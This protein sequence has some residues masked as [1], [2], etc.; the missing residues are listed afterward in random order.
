MTLVRSLKC[1]QDEDKDV[2]KVK[3][4]LGQKRLPDKNRVASESVVIKSLCSQWDR[5]V[6]EHG[7]LY[8][9]WTDHVTSRDTLQAV[10][11]IS[12]R[13]KVL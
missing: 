10:V 7:L 9:K 11:T 2:K 4:W 6:I 1:L 5:L 13:R 8:R 3:D 12:E